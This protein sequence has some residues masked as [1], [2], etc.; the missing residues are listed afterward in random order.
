VPTKWLGG[1]PIKTQLSGNRSVGGE[2]KGGL[3]GRKMK[4][5]ISKK[6]VS[7]GKDQNL[8][9]PLGNKPL[10]HRQ[11]QRKPNN[12][13]CRRTNSSFKWD[14]LCGGWVSLLSWLSPRAVP[15]FPKYLSWLSPL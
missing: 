8:I 3:S 1:S 11:S 4:G 15:K 2:Q 10:S 13:N 12:S 9:A 6:E 7:K 14:E 5:C